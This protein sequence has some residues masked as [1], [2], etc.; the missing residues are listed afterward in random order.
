MIGYDFPWVSQDLAPLSHLA[1]GLM[2]EGKLLDPEDNQY[3]P[4]AFVLARHGLTP[5]NV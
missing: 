2:G 1:L 3:K 5:I 4:A